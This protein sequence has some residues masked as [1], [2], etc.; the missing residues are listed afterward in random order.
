MIIM[1]NIVVKVFFKRY[2][3]H[4]VLILIFIAIR[5]LPGSIS[6][7]WDS[8]LNDIAI[9]GISSVL[10]ALLLQIPNDSHRDKIAKH[11]EK[12]LLSSLILSLK[13]YYLLWLLRLDIMGY[14]TNLTPDDLGLIVN[15]LFD[16][17][18]FTNDEYCSCVYASCE[19]IYQ[20]VLSV[21][22]SLSQ[23]IIL[24]GVTEE[25][26]TFISSLKELF[27]LP[28]RYMGNDQSVKVFVHDINEKL[29]TILR[30]YSLTQPIASQC[31]NMR[32]ILD[33]VQL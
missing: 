8:A 9:G 13:G 15:S 18:T 28:Y 24:E 33:S 25:T 29:P 7:N 5:L 16:D 32:E 23:F 3:I 1:N 20:S 21:E 6:P 17:G 14:D 10:V 26:L 31:L 4:L 2:R 12:Q 19:E 22:S 27:W 11:S 30:S